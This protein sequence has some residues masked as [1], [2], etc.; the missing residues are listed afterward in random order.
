MINYTVSRLRYNKYTVM[1]TRQRKILMCLWAIRKLPR[2]EK[3]EGNDVVVGSS[4]L[5]DSE[6]SS[7][8][9]SASISRIRNDR[10]L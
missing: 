4:S 3:P 8:L 2:S 6:K 1:K 10:F 5:D 7:M 9:T